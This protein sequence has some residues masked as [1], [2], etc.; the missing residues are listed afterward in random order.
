MKNSLRGRGRGGEESPR[1]VH[2]GNEGPLGW[3]DVA[4]SE[5]NKAWGGGITFLTLV[6]A[7]PHLKHW[8]T[9]TKR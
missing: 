6:A 1:G 3:D 4:S 5:E 7:S 2:Q 9:V 8:V